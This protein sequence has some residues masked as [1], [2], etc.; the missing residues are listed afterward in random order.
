MSAEGS[1]GP[2]GVLI[3][4]DSI[5]DNG[6]EQGYGEFVVTLE[7][8]GDGDSTI[9]LRLGD[10]KGTIWMVKLSEVEGALKL[11]KRRRR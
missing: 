3:A 7:P 10:K 5:S 8:D 11:L 2:R 9:D 6:E 4:A 1:Y